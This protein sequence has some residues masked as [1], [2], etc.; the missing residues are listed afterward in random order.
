M[1]DSLNFQTIQWRFTMIKTILI[2]IL[3]A[4]LVIA[5]GFSVYNV[6]A[7]PQPQAAKQQ[8]QTAQGAGYDANGQISGQGATPQAGTGTQSAA[9]A[10]AVEPGAATDSTDPAFAQR[11]GA[12]GAGG[13]GN[14]NRRGQ[15]GTQGGAG[16]PQPQNGMTGIVTYTGQVSAYAAPEFTLLTTD[17]RAILVQLGN[18]GYA[19]GLGLALQDGE[20]VTVIG[21]IDSSG[22]LAVASITIQS[23]GQT[24]TLRDGTTGRPSW[25]GGR[26]K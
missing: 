5:V 11:A 18:Q 10:E 17:G 6:L 8:A 26:N 24:F 12:Q 2:S 16:V 4:I 20:E 19:E 21:F 7:A 22:A 9:L 23:T 15:S 14:G 25:A 13:Q 1:L 3:A